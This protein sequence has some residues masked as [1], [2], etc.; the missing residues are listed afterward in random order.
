ME[1]K[2][3]LPEHNDNISHAQPVKEFFEIAASLAMIAL[4]IFVGLGLLVDRIVDGISAETEASISRMVSVPTA[5]PAPLQA[6][7]RQVQQLVDQLRACTLLRRPTP[8]YLH[9]AEPVN[10]A[11]GPGGNITVFTGLLGA[12]LSENGLSFVLA[13]EL[14]HIEHRDHLRGMGRAIA[15]AAVIATITGGGDIDAI[16]GP[17]LHLGTAK[18]SRTR[19]AA[20]DARA[21]EI[22]QCRYG[23]VGGATQLFDSMKAEDSSWPLSHY[24]ASHPAMQERIA[25]IHALAAARRFPVRQTVALAAPAAGQPA[26]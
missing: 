8:I 16:V 21:L 25:T 13:H 23:H 17:G 1:Y 10:A 2:P 11:V 26:P 9:D 5:T 7:Q 24:M 20:A 15:M 18:F 12:R 19:E 3:V 4:L 6:R 14:A 22:L